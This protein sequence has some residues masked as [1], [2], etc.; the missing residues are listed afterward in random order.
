MSESVPSLRNDEMPP[1]IADPIVSM[2]VPRSLV[3]RLDALFPMLS[4]FPD[5]VLD[6]LTPDVRRA[7]QIGAL[8]WF[9]E[10]MHEQCE[11]AKSPADKRRDQRRRAALLAAMQ[12]DEAEDDEQTAKESAP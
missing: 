6:A 7:E 12:A 8:V 4:P 10:M 2:P 5:K 3:A 1:A 11:R 9:F